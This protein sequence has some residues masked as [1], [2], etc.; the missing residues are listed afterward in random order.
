MFLGL[1]TKPGQAANVSS[2]LPYLTTA[3]RYLHAFTSLL[4]GCTK[5]VTNSNTIN[6]HL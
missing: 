3:Y 5:G 1:D 6:R 4:L 2:T